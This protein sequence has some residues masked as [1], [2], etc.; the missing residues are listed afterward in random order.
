MTIR[1]QNVKK[2]FMVF[3]NI[4]EDDVHKGIKRT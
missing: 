1:E 3:F 4:A 2:K